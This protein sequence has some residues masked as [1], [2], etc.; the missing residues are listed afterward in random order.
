ME[1]KTLLMDLFFEAETHT[2]TRSSLQEAFKYLG[3]CPWNQTPFGIYEVK[4]KNDES[5][6]DDNAY[7]I[8][9]T[10]VYKG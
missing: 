3:L 10:G 8:D 2:M 4:K 7:L 9:V 5:Q 6:F 1:R